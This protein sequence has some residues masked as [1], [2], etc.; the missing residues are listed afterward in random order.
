MTAC[1]KYTE[2]ECRSKGFRDVVGSSVF[3]RGRSE[4][5]LGHQCP[6]HK[7]L[8]MGEKKGR[9]SSSTWTGHRRFEYWLSN[10]CAVYGH[11]SLKLDR[12]WADSYRRS[13][14]EIFLFDRSV[15]QE[16]SAA[17]W[18]N[19][20]SSRQSGSTWGCDKM[21]QQEIILPSAWINGGRISLQPA[22]I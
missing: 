4:T 2:L 9:T 20:H 21:P 15:I 1:T 14:L 11:A 8:V 7:N 13:L 19:Y 18:R 6:A 3:R 22:K 17:D 5:K 12:F 16:D 10:N